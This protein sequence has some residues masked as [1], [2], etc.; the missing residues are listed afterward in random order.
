[1]TILIYEVEDLESA[2]TFLKTCKSTVIVTNPP[3]SSRYY[4]M[5][6]LDYMFKSLQEEF[7]QIV[8]I[9]LNLGNDNAAL[10]T[11]RKLGYSTS[12]TEL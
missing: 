4:G 10:F 11:A 8:K 6:V 2:R 12:L 9:T 7:P 1:M 5:L 3:G